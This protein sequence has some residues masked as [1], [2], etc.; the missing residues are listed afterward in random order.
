MRS[1]FETSR[2]LLHVTASRFDTCAERALESLKRM[3]AA[4][5][6]SGDGTHCHQQTEFNSTFGLM[7]VATKRYFGRLRF[8]LCPRLLRY[9][10]A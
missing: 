1:I 3:V 8:D 6:D 5:R 10:S 2:I 7:E 9:F 4:R